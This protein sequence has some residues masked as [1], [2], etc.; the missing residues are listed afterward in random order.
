[1]IRSNKG[2]IVIK[3]SREYRFERTAVYVIQNV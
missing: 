3:G 1:M 2:M